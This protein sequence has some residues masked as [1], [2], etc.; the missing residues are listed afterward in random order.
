MVLR[1]DDLDLAG[2]RLSAGEGRRLELAVA[3][4][5]LILGSEHYTA[6]PDLVPVA[7]DV[8][9]MMGGGYA[10]RLAF[11]AAVSGPCMRCLKPAAPPVEVEA[12]EIDRP[13]GGEEL[14]SPYVHDETLD[15]AGWARD[16]FAL[17]MPA[18]VLCRADCAGLCPI[19][20]ADLNEAGPEHHHESVPDP[21]WAKLRELELE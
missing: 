1:S 21:R 9:R 10:L 4:E 13:G 16:A 7:L 19:C 3:I 17:A 6:E 8:S 15:L 5:P 12:R 18:K 11:T 2:L 14:E 20:A